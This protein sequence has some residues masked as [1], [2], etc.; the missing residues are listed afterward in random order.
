MC[1]TMIVVTMEDH[2]SDACD[3]DHREAFKFFSYTL[4]CVLPVMVVIPVPVSLFYYVVGFQVALC[5]HSLSQE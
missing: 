4:Q 1:V 5:I 3:S 2:A